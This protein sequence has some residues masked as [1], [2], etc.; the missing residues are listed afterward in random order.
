[1]TGFNIEGQHSHTES[2][3]GLFYPITGIRQL[4]RNP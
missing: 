1:M 3:M 2:T 4:N